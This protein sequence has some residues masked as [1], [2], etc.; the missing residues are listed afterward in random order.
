M[1]DGGVIP[2][3]FNHSTIRPTTMNDGPKLFTLAKR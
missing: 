3:R 2:R 1:N